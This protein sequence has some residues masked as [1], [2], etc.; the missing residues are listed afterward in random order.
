MFIDGGHRF[1]CSNDVDVRSAASGVTILVH[2]RWIEPNKNRISL[3]NRVMAID[4]QISIK[5]IRIIAIDLF[6]A[7]YESSYFQNRFDDLERL[8]MEACGK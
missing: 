5:V 6:H 2:C 3:N 7:D 8:I 1:I 4:L